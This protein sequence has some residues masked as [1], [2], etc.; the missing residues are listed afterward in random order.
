MITSTLR[1]ITGEAVTPGGV[2]PYTI[3]V[4]GIA[5]PAVEVIM[6]DGAIIG[7]GGGIGRSAATGGRLCTQVE[8]AP[9]IEEKEFQLKV[10]ETKIK[11]LEAFTKGIEQI[12]KAESLEAGSQLDLYRGLVADMATTIG[13]ERDGEDRAIAAQERQT[14]NM[15]KPN[16]STPTQPQTAGT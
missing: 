9:S 12:A 14:Q 6:G 5:T 7:R 1:R 15:G 13:L 11:V 2:E 8:T 10:E 3:G 4:I 16:G